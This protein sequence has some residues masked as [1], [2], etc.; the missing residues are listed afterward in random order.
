MPIYNQVFPGFINIEPKEA[1]S[2]RVAIIPNTSP[3]KSSGA[4]V[5]CAISLPVNG[6]K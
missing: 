5:Q 6:L 1:L 2:C 4:V 3:P